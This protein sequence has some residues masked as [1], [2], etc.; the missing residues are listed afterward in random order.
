MHSAHLGLDCPTPESP[1]RKKVIVPVTTMCGMM[2]ERTMKEAVTNG[3]A[4]APVGFLITSLLAVKSTAQQFMASL[5]RSSL[6][7]ASAAAAQGQE[8]SSRSP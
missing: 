2:D 4:V 8:P 1:F 5:G 6:Y 7:K 3:L